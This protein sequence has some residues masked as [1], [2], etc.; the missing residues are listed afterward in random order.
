MAAPQHAKTTASLVRSLSASATGSFF[1]LL[2]LLDASFWDVARSWLPCGRV[3]RCMLLSRGI[4]RALRLMSCPRS[5]C[6][7]SAGPGVGASAVW[8]SIL[9]ATYSDIHDELLDCGSSIAQPIICPN[10]AK[11]ACGACAGLGVQ[12]LAR[13]VPEFCVVLRINQLGSTLGPQR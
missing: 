9:F 10:N 4:M 1:L 11:F 13:A 5:S 7:R 12:P 2:F 6:P 8:P 3:S